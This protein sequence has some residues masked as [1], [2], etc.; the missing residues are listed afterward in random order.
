MA[1]KQASPL[2]IVIAVIILL[3]VI[4]VIYTVTWGK[5][6]PGSDDDESTGMPAAMSR[7]RGPGGPPNAA[8]AQSP[9]GNEAATPPGSA[10]AEGAGAAAPAAKGGASPAAP[11]NS[12]AAGAGAK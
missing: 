6:K 1:E 3:A 2:A 4:A 5:Q 10:N 8:S 7:G 12:A 11:V 9:P